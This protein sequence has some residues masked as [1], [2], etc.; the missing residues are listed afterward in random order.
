MSAAVFGPSR[1]PHMLH[2]MLRTG[3]SAM[4]IAAAVIGAPAWAQDSDQDQSV[5]GAAQQT[6]VAATTGGA[7]QAGEATPSDNPTQVDTEGDIVVT[8]IRASLQGARDRKRNAEQVIDSITAQDI[9]ALPD[10]SVS[11]ALQRVPG[12]TLQRTNENRD[13]ARLSSEGGGVFIRGLSFVR[14]ELNGRDVFSANNG[15]GLSFE[16]VSSDLLAGV[17]VFKNPSA[18]LVEGGIGGIVNLRTRKPFDSKGFVLAF[19]GDIN[20]ADLLDK[21]FLSGNI[22]ASDR[23]DTGLGEIGIL[24]SYSIGNIGNRTDSITGG[25]YDVRQLTAANDGLAAGT[26]VYVPAGMGFRRIDWSQKRTA[27]DGSIQWAPSPTLLIT[28]EALISQAEPEDIEYAVGDYDTPDPNT[29]NG[30]T[31]DFNEDGVLQSGVLLGRNLNFN[32][33]AGKQKKKTQDYSLNLR[34]TPNERWAFG[35]DVQY[36]KSSAEVYSMTAFTQVGTPSTIAFDFSGNDPSMEISPTS[37]TGTLDDKSLYWWAAA[38]DHI[39]DNDAEEWAGRADVEYTFEEDSFLRSFRVGGRFTDRTAV[40]RQTGYNWALLS[41]QYWGGGP[42]VYLDQTGYPGG[43]QNA[44]LPNQSAF[45]SFPDFFRNNIPMP[46]GGFW[47]PTAGLV[48]NGTANAYSYLRSTQSAGWGW[49]PLSGDYSLA[50]PAGDNV[51]GGIN[52]QDEKTYAG[53]A[54]LRFGGE[55]TFAGHFD[56]NIGVRVVR[57]ETGSLGSALRVGTITTTCTPGVGGATAADCALLASAQ[58]F[59]T[60]DIGGAIQNSD[61]S[62]TDVLPSLNLRFFLMDNLQ[63]R[64]AAA[65]AIVRPTFSQL[66]PFTQLGFAFDAN[67]IA[68]GVGVGGR[69]TAFTGTTGNAELR[70]TKSNQFD[71][72]LEYYFGRS[73]SLTLAGFY[74]DI[75]DYIFAGVVERS[76]TSGGQ[77]LTFDLTQQTNGSEGKIKGFEVGYTQFFDMLPGAL[78]GLGFTGNY[79]FVDSSGGKNTAVNVFDANQTTNAAKELP[80][81]GLSRNSFN[82]A[83]IYEKYGVSARVAYNW[84]STYLLTTSAANINY[85]VWAEDYGQLDASFLY[86]VTPNFKLGVQ[87]TNLLNSRTY[88]QVGDPDLKPRYGWTDT[89]RRIAVLVRGVF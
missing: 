30:S 60:G 19:S 76:F 13:P 41:A 20:Y 6:S 48:Q 26:N 9:G 35:A 71:A 22:L 14:S 53:Y 75:S 43:P 78:G 1:Q 33:R 74:K 50:A 32:T 27:F 70:P 17:D 55:E 58:A 2:A 81:E 46:T 8:G 84:R 68:N 79:T 47:F 80:L 86:S 44:G 38:M 61:G 45:Q 54:L 39:E 62:Y 73:N 24:L 15:R 7:G 37:S 23:F 66:N 42:P 85:P 63:L 72:S 40:T 21:S 52:N 83:G 28:A 31:F 89:D 5:E 11:E 57:T 16:D 18:D 77:T 82:L 64:L 69:R 4:A 34:W 88:L 29:T 10:R 59:S 65:K 56:G 87:G 49:T 25:R 12:V 67:G 51:S 36:I 3:A